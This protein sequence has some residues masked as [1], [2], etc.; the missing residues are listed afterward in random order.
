MMRA[1]AHFDTD[2]SGYITED[3]LEAA[4]RVRCRVYENH[5]ATFVGCLHES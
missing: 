2:N 5:K 1:F 4:L 3:E